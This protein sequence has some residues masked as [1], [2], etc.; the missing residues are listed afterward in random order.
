[1]LKLFLITDAPF[2]SAFIESTFLHKYSYILYILTFTKIK[3][4]CQAYSITGV[5]SN[6]PVSCVLCV[7]AATR[8]EFWNSFTP[9]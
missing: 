6:C 8:S 2:Y 4:S 5:I 9:R 1:M 7:A 3:H